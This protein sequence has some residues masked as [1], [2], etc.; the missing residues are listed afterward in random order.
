MEGMNQTRVHCIHIW[1]CHSKTI[2]TAITNNYILICLYLKLAK[3]HVF[4]LIFY[5]FSFTKSENRRA[6]Q[7]L[8]GEGR[9]WHQWEGG[10]GRE[11]DRRMNTTQIM[12]THVCKCKNDNCWNGSG[13][14]EENE[15]EW[16]RGEFKWD[17]FDTL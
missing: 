11:R 4:L 3:H 15:G 7:V 17:I 1:K 14:V 6:E 8:L 9:K 2:C 5:V 13:I 16:W 10:S 12:C